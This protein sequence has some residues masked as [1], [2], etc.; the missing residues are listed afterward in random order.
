MNAGTSIVR[1]SRSRNRGFT[2]LEV[3]IALVVLSVGLLGIAAM[4]NFSLKAN[5]SAYLRT[6]AEAFAYNIVDKMRANQNAAL[7]G[8]YNI[9]I[10]T[11]VSANIAPS[12]PASPRNECSAA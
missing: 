10:G 9:A 8:S 2:L 11:S 6:Q 4:M 3:L 1:A 5:D 12:S 7:N